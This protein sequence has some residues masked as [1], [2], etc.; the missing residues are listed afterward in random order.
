MQASV[1][2]PAMSI[3]S[4]VAWLGSALLATCSLL[5]LLLEAPVDTVSLSGNELAWSWSAFD[6]PQL[7][8]SCSGL[9][10]LGAMGPLLCEGCGESSK[11]SFWASVYCL[12]TDVPPKSA[13]EDP[14]MCFCL[15]IP[16]MTPSLP[17]VN[18]TSLKS[19]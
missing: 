5:L 16:F 3:D 14:C 19:S 18:C 13:G 9:A 1:I 7:V 6:C 11:S 4:V 17:C 2:V 8:G 15:V 10:A 12:C